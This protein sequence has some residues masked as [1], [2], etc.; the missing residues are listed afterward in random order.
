MAEY[1]RNM[2]LRV[3]VLAD[4]TS[5]WA[6][7]LRE[8]SN[9]LGEMPSDSGF[10]AYV[11]GRLASFYERAGQV[12][13]L[14]NPERKGSTTIFGVVSPPGSDFTDPV[15]RATAGIVQNLWGLDKGLAEILHFPAVN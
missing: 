14:G 9:R 13:C 1:H 8:V 11:G 15:T 3:S 4:S 2:G 7:A 10:P 6:E 5:R 12:K